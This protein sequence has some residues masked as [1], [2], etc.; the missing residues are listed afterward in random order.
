MLFYVVLQVAR[1]S[2]SPLTKLSVGAVYLE[3]I[4]LYFVPGPSTF[5][6]NL[7]PEV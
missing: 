2:T 3:R 6:L 7:H 5:N 4:A 1:S